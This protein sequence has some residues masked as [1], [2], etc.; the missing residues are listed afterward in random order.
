[1]IRK[2]LKSILLPASVHG[3]FNLSKP[4][5]TNLRITGGVLSMTLGMTGTTKLT[6]DPQAISTEKPTKA[7][8]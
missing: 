1:M 2:G 5:I 6:L 4:I 7:K 3:Q 8:R